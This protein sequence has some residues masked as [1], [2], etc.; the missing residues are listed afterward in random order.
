MERLCS[1]ELVKLVLHNV[2]FSSIP[3]EGSQ[4]NSQVMA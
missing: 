3:L 2:F 1:D 4:G